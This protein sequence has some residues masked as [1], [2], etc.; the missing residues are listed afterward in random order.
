[1]A[2]SKGI[3]LAEIAGLDVGDVFFPNGLPCLRVQLRSD[4]T[5]KWAQQRCVPAGWVD[6]EA[7]AV[8]ELQ[9]QAR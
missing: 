5:S 6:A 7:E 3:G 2:F 4:I 1:V 8:L 9:G